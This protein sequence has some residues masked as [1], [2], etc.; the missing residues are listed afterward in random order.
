MSNPEV[1]TENKYANCWRI[2]QFGQFGGAEYSYQAPAQHHF[3]AQM[4]A[5]LHHD[6]TSLIARYALKSVDL[7]QAYQAS[8]NAIKRLIVVW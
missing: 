4:E 6:G 5:G 3:K 8:A 2:R 1:N 7:A